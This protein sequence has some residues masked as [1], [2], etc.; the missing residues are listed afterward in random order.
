MRHRH[1]DYTQKT[2]CWENLKRF[3]PN[4]KAVTKPVKG[5]EPETNPSVV[6]LENKNA[7]LKRK[8]LEGIRKRLVERRRAIL[9]TIEE[10]LDRALEP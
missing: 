7:A 6:F 5:P 2:S 1:D 3:Y 9:R 10:E 4:L 8:I